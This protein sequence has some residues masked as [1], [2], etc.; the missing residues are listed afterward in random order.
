MSERQRRDS[1]PPILPPLRARHDSFPGV[2]VWGMV[3]PNGDEACRWESVDG[4]WVAV[5][6]GSDDE[7]GHAIVTT[8]DG[9]RDVVDSYEDALAMAKRWRQGGSDG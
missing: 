9:R 3:P 7:L 5:S 6:I 8:S 1:D 2:V 4:R